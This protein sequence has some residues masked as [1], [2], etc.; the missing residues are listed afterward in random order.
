MTK[1]GA[2]E[3][4]RPTHG[5]GAGAKRARRRAAPPAPRTRDPAGTRAR[6]LAA[7]TREFARHGLG[8]ARVDRIAAS[9]DANKRMLYYYFGDKDASLPRGARTRLRGHPRPPNR[10]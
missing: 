4:R 3:A 10:S 6:I 8:G 1:N 2:L 5:N 9:A 7:A